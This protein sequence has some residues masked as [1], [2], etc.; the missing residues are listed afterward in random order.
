[1]SVLP[2]IE[3]LTTLV[4][5]CYFLSCAAIAIGFCLLAK[6]EQEKERK[7]RE[8]LKNDIADDVCARVLGADYVDKKH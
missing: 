3:E 4:V 1:M 6:H 2:T 7:R 5:I 8:K